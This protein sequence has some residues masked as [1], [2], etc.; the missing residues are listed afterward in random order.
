MKKIRLF[1][2]DVFCDDLNFQLFEEKCIINTL[3]ASAIEWSKKDDVYK[4]ALLNSDILLPDGVAVQLASR[5]LFN[6]KIKKISGEE[7]FF[8]VLNYLNESKGTCFFLGSS[9]YVLNLIKKRLAV[10][11]IDITSNSYAPPYRDVFSDIEKTDMINEV[12]K[13]SPNVLF[14]GISAP[15]QEKLIYEISS[16]LNVD[17]I[18]N[19]GAVFEFYAGT[20]KR[21]SK[22]WQKLKLEWLVIWFIDPKR[23][24]KKEYL[25]ILNFLITLL[26]EKIRLNKTIEH[27]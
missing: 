13:F 15:K 23:L 21:P 26:K 12:N 3:N 24:R 18:C 10:E 7:L 6:K 16:Q 4:N 5:F 11:Y 19:I 27:R 9:D 14:V 8:F 2:F 25:S 20:L 17:I 1:G 22:F